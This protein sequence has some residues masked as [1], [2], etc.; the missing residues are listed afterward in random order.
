[1][2]ENS[3]IEWT[4][5]TFN[6]WRGCTKVSDGCK[7]CYADTLSKRNPK[8]LGVWGPNGQ[9]VVAAESY[10]KQPRLWHAKAIAAGERHRV[11]CA[12]L[13][14]VFEGR[15]TMP[16]SS[17][18]AVE[19]ARRRLFNLIDDTPQLDWLLLT[20]RPQNIQDMLPSVRIGE[21]AEFRQNLWIGTSVENMWAADER[22]H[23]LK[24]VPAAVRFLSVEPLIGPVSLRLIAEPGIHW[25]IVG[26]E[27]GA[28]A[29]PMDLDWARSVRD[30]CKSAG[31]AF[32]MK[33]MEINGKVTGDLS[34][35][36]EDLRVREFPKPQ[37]KP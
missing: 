12:S 25:V 29:R 30:Q 17:W 31:V 14:D 7:N 9:R 2:A 37:V 11:F 26:C 27:S 33:Q 36:P 5:H 13:A 19:S 35:F 6:P 18:E 32:F 23:W 21:S 28:H 24:K 22:I 10:W 16:E 20:K 1:M 15:D 34:D 3:N 4:T 8:T